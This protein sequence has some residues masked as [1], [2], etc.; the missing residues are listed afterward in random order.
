MSLPALIKR[1]VPLAG[2]TTLG[3]GGPADY[4][5][6]ITNE[7]ELPVV[8][9]FARDNGLDIFAIGRGSNILFADAGFRG[10][11]LRIDLKS[12]YLEGNDLWVGAGVQISELVKLAKAGRTGFESFAGLPG[13]VGGAV[14]G[15]AG[16]YG[17]QFWDVVAKVRFFN[18]KT[19]ETLEAKPD[20]FSYRQSVFGGNPEWIICAVQLRAER[21]DPELIGRETKRILSTRQASQPKEKSCGCFFK[22]PIRATAGQLIDRTGLKGERFGGAK[23][24]EVHANFF[25]NAGGATA[26]DFLE[27]IEIVKGR[28][29]GEFNILLEEEIIKIG[30]F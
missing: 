26:N 18:G 25:V 28:V 30:E 8:C 27:L 4:F 17:K 19:F 11:V 3:V 7:Q 14:Y 10:L 24:S 9:N 16:C 23:V 12:F 6:E 29:Y 15:N 21:G 22:N 2:F 1:N 5:A 20:L 13:N